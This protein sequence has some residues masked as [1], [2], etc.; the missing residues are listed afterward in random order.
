MTSP[1]T[2]T[3]TDDMV[4]AAWDAWAAYNSATNGQSQDDNALMRAALTA[5]LSTHPHT[6][7]EDRATAREEWQPIETALGEED[8]VL[9]ASQSICG[10]GYFS[11][12]D[13]AWCYIDW[14]ANDA[15]EIVRWPQKPTHWMPLPKPPSSSERSERLPH[16]HTGGREAVIEECAL[17]AMKAIP[18]G[19]AVGFWEMGCKIGVTDA[20]NRIRALSP[21]SHKTQKET[22]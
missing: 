13:K 20:A 9:L 19:P 21:P 7:T 4:T 18:P 16:P 22:T 17:E 8:R 1:T 12:I 10:L 6:G 5:A 2:N 11:T 14:W 15:D 3:V